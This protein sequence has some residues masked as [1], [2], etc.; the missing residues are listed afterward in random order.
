MSRGRAPSNSMGISD[1][2]V[3]VGVVAAVA[4]LIVWLAA[5]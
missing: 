1:L 2:L 4:A 3:F 5:R